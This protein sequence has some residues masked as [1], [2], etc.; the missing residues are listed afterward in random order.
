ML[1]EAAF[2]NQT[3]SAQTRALSQLYAGQTLND[4]TKYVVSFSAT[5]A[6]NQFQWNSASWK[7]LVYTSGCDINL[8]HDIKKFYRPKRKDRRQNYSTWNIDYINSR[9]KQ[10]PPVHCHPR[11]RRKVL[12]QQLVDLGRTWL[13]SKKSIIRLFHG[14]LLEIRHLQIFSQ[15]NASNCSVKWIK[16]IFWCRKLGMCYCF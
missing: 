11:A 14:A 4:Q 10:W 15:Q 1:S 13:D 16:L 3:S 8:Q 7:T 2:P 12:Y 9:I 5:G 6:N